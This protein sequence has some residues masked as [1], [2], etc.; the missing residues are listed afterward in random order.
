[1]HEDIARWN[2]VIG[3]TDTGTPE[4]STIPILKMIDSGS[5]RECADAEEGVEEN[6]HS[7]AVEMLRLIRKGL[8]KTRVQRNATYFEGVQTVAADILPGP[9]WVPR[10]PNLYP[11]L[12]DLFV[13]ALRVDRD[14]RPSLAE[15]LVVARNEGEQ[16]LVDDARDPDADTIQ[17]LVHNA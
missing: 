3:D 10:F 8:V 2:I 5:S 7:A 6:L 16:V 13:Q 14:R 4:H 17:R 12:R 9:H 1:M 11:Q 15:M